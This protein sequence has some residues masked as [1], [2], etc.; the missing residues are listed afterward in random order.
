MMD[1]WRSRESASIT[2][3][4]MERSVGP[5]AV[6]KALALP[7]RAI[8]GADRPSEH[9]QQPGHAVLFQGNVIGLLNLANKETDYAER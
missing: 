3:R 1:E 5:R 9:P 8:R 2:A 6:G 4:E 7:P